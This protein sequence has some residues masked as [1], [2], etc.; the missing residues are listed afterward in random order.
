MSPREK[1]VENSNYII[2]IIRDSSNLNFF[3]ENGLKIVRDFFKK[4]VTNV[5]GVTTIV[6]DRDSCDQPLPP[7]EIRSE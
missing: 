6:V 3:H 5:L 2:N 4:I 1:E 7:I